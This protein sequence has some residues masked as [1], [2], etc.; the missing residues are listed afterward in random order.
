M[1]HTREKQISAVNGIL[2]KF[3]IPGLSVVFVF[4]L[5]VNLLEGVILPRW[6]DRQ[7][8]AS[9]SPSDKAV[10]RVS[11]S[12]STASD[13]SIP[14]DAV[15]GPP[16]MRSVDDDLSASLDKIS[17]KYGAVAVQAAIIKDGAVY[18][19]YNY[20]Y[21]NRSEEKPVTSDTVFRVASLSKMI[22]AMAVMKMVD[23]GQMELDG[24]IG[25][26]L[27]YTV[28]SKKYPKTSITPRMLMTHT[29]SITDS[30]GFLK[31]RSAGSSVPLKE[32]LSRSSSY[33]GT[34]PGSV[35][36]Y[37]N[38][39]I[40]VLTAAA[41]KNMGMPF[42]EYTENELFKPLSVDASFLASRISDPDKIACLY[43][44]DGGVGYSV[45]RQRKEKCAQELGQTHHIYQGNLT[46]SA[47][48]YAGLLC[49]LLNHGRDQTG[50]Q[51]LSAQSV[52][53]ILKVQHDAGSRQYGLCS[54]ISTKVVTGRRMYCHTG[55]NFGMYSSFAFDPDD[56]SGVVVLTSG[57]AASKESSG[58][59][60]VCGDIIREIY[61][62]LDEPRSLLIPA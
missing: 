61:K 26:Y 21:A 55:S 2:R 24:D 43:N 39:G 23:N 20:G 7:G 32:L 16:A 29:S 18:A 19:Y 57:A 4:L 47:A 44:S 51:I 35:Y 22:D 5:V 52:Q 33:S 48:D 36:Q 45:S 3:V 40:A 14:D 27:G 37:S 13:G 50:K 30:S 42:Y 46:I 53:E 6:S 34:R 9:A 15:Q 1:H 17:K 8:R 60:D 62:S 11:A 54:V 56:S 28:R 58:V 10:D 49:L 25:S 41:E 12:E 38:F 59:Y 31:S